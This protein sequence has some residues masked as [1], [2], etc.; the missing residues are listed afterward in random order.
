MSTRPNFAPYVV[1]PNAYGSP[2]NSSSMAVNLISQPTIVSRLSMINYACVWSGSSPVGTISVQASDDY[3]LG[4]EGLNNPPINPGTWN[5]LP[6]SYY[7][8]T[9]TSTV[10]AIPVSG[11]TGNGMID[12][13]TSGFYAIR[14]IYTAGSGTGS[15]TVTINAKVA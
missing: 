4:P 9:T 3:E 15:L 13:A 7:N 6:V 12:V 10:T 8:G 2:A 14:L 5:T 1:L 11:S